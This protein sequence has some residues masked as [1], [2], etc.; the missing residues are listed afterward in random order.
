MV[1]EA[2]ETERDPLAPLCEVV[3]GFGWVVADVGAMPGNDLRRP[4]GDGAAETLHLEGHHRVTEVAVDL[5]DP[6]LGELNTGVV[7]DLTLNG[8][9]YD[10]IIGYS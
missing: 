6:C 8:T 2:N 10:T 1:S 9:L 5:D 3:H 7:V 4:V